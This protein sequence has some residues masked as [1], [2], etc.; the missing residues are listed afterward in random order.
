ME[1]ITDSPVVGMEDRTDINHPQN[2]LIKEK[3][4]F[5]LDNQH[6]IWFPE[7]FMLSLKGLVFDKV[8][9]LYENDPETPL[10][11]VVLKVLDGV[12]PHLTEGMIVEI[13]PYIIEKWHKKH[14]L[15]SS[16]KAISKEEEL[17]FA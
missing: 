15:D 11:S 10:L 16:I 8:K 3:V 17:V 4:Q 1:L 2:A 9:I 14:S 7:K 5:M 13:V 12:N 6:K